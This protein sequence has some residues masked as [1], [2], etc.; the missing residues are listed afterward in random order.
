VP[1]AGAP[2]GNAKWIEV[3]LSEQHL[4][5]W[6]SRSV[7]FHSAVSTGTAAHPTVIGTFAVYQKLRYDDMEGGTPGIDYYFTPDVPYTMY[8]YDGYA[9]HGAY[10]HN[11]FGYPMSHGCVNLPVPAA[12]WMYDW[13]PI[14]TT[15]WVHP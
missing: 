10:W 11:N 6:S 15:V 12:A 2:S 8:F 9:I 1:P 14:G 5:A 13:T 7:V 4:W 3:D